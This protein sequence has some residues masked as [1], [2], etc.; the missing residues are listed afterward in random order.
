MK[1]HR[2]EELARLM[3]EVREGTEAYPSLTEALAA[4]REE[5]EEPLG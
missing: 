2:G 5:E 4:S 1:A 3:D